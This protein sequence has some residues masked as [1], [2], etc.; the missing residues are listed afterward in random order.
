MDDIKRL[1]VGFS[2]GVVAT[3]A[4]S[5]FMIFAVVTGMSPMPKPIPLAI[6]STLGEWRPMF[7]LVVFAVISHLAYGGFWGAV[8]SGMTKHVTILKGIGLGLVLWLLMGIVALPL[9]GWGF[10][11]S[12][13]DSRIAV[14]TFFLHLVYGVTLGWLVDHKQPAADKTWT[15]AHVH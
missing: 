4:M 3:I 10:F 1:A 8:L 9:L 13:V 6:V 15:S 11:G 12:A 7:L 5:L 14:A 2:W